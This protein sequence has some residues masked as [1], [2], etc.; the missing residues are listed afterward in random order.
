MCTRLRWH[1]P[2]SSEA[3]KCQKVS[4]GRARFACT[5]CIKAESTTTMCERNSYD[6]KVCFVIFYMGGG[7]P[8]LGYGAGIPVPRA[9]WI[10]C[11]EKALTRRPRPRPKEPLLCA[12]TH[13]PAI[14]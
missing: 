7:S 9:D 6:T 5:S 13:S 12:C 8:A 4:H 2:S 3:K 10:A 11:T 14:S 1:T